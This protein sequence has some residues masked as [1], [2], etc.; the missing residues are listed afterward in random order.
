MTAIKMVEGSL[1]SEFYL[2]DYQSVGKRRVAK[3]NEDGVLVVSE[4]ASSSGALP[5]RGVV[6]EGRSG[7]MYVPMAFLSWHLDASHGTP[8]YSRSL[9]LMIDGKLMGDGF[10]VPVISWSKRCL[11][12]EFDVHLEDGW[13]FRTKYTAPF[14]REFFMQMNVGGTLDAQP[15]DFIEQIIT[16]V[17]ELRPDWIAGFANQNIS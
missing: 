6:G 11:S 4:S 10:S 17:A 12:R 15:V 3:I 9:V 5:L 7:S 2:I 14:I 8:D 1:D 13:S 16:V